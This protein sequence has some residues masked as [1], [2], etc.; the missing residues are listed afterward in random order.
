MARTLLALLWLLSLPSPAFAEK[1]N[2]ERAH[3]RVFFLDDNSM[4][5]RQLLVTLLAVEALNQAVRCKM[6]EYTLV[7]TETDDTITM[8]NVRWT[9]VDLDNNVGLTFH[10][11]GDKEIVTIRRD[12]SGKKLF[13]VLLHE[14]GHAFGLHHT[15]RGIMSATLEGAPGIN[16][17]FPSE[18]SLSWADD[19]VAEMHKQHLNPCSKAIPS[20]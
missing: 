14:L 18:D 8:S 6:V 15:H 2:R 9:P 10:D 7:R 1:T 17:H 19:L 13:N 5:P 3:R 20:H 16:S 12:L 4:E 11:D